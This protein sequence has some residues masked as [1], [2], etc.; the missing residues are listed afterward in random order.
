LL[1]DF[2]RVNADDTPV[3]ILR[4][5][6]GTP[7]QTLGTAF[8]IKLSLRYNETSTLTF[9]VPAFANGEPTPH[10][11]DIVGMRIVDV[12]GWGQF[13][14][15]NPSAANNGEREIKSCEAYSLEYE[16]TYKKLS[17]EEDT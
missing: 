11:D 12:N 7:I 17:L 1:I 16:L 6:D 10:Y 4:N 9:D 3:L 5:L 14:L 15:V 13:I 8:N 2:N